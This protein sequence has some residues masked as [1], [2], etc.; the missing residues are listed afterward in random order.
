MLIILHGKGNQSFLTQQFEDDRRDLLE[1]STDATQDTKD[2]YG[3]TGSQ[4]G[5]RTNPD[6]YEIKQH[7]FP[8]RGDVRKKQTLDVRKVMPELGEMSD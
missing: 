3:I 7:P 1:D 5:G 8:V 4:G 6:T 2:W